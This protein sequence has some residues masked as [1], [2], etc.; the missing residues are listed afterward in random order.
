MLPAC[1]VS[2][3][4]V[5]LSFEI[6]GH[7][8]KWR[9]IISWKVP[10]RKVLYR[11]FVTCAMRALLYLPSKKYAQDDTELF[12]LQ[13][14][15]PDKK[16]RSSPWRQYADKATFVHRVVRLTSPQKTMNLS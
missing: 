16:L 11:S 10:S 7:V 15:Q 3:D 4:Q 6:Y 14:P 13:L 9:E 5:G 1:C 12:S 8:T 2:L